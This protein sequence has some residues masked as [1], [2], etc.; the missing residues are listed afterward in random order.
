VFTGPTLAALTR[1]SDSGPYGDTSTPFDTA[2]GET[3]WIAVGSFS[4]IPSFDPLT[5]T[6]STQ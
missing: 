2:A 1:V 5:L 3:Y 4:A 6:L